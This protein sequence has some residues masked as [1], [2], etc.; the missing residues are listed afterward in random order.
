VTLKSLRI[1]TLN[2]IFTLKLQDIEI[3]LR[4]VYSFSTIK[5]D[6]HKDRINIVTDLLKLLL[7]NSSVYTF[8][9]TRHPTLEVFSMLGSSQ[10]A[11]GRV[12]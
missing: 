5:G 11:N 10:R 3:Y 4:E 7:G 2:A 8:Q 12:R 9:H 1:Q 6:S